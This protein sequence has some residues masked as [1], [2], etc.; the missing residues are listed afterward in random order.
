MDAD[1]A[2]RVDR[3]PLARVLLRIFGGESRAEDVH[4]GLRLRDGD[5][6]P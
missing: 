6:I 1:V 4:R 3:D 5:A 2:R